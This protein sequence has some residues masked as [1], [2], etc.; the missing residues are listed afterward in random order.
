MCMVIDKF[1]DAWISVMDK[2]PE[3]TGSYIVAT[4]NGA[5]CTA[6]FYESEYW[7]NHFAGRVARYITHWMPLPKHPMGG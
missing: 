5:V 3:K 7:G 1:Q 6:K 2:L 4:E